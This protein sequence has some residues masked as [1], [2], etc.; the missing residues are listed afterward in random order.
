MGEAVSAL[1]D[2][3]GSRPPSPPA[4]ALGRGEPLSPV[5]LVSLDVWPGTITMSPSRDLP[6]PTGLSEYSYFI[7]KKTEAQG[8][9]MV[10]PEGPHGVLQSHT[11]LHAI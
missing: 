9:D 3:P 11:I 10:H 8:S 7:G 5:P 6:M 2:R 4:V 1:T